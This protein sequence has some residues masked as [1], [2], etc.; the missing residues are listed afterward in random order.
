MI[1]SYEANDK[2][3]AKELATTAYLD[4]FE[5][6]ES[7]IGK[8]LSDKGESLLREKLRD[9][10]DPNATLDEIKQNIDDINV[11]LDDAAMVLSNSI[12]Q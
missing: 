8:E 3:K 12:A 7:P 4:N 10:I 9:Q 2:V 6:I 11:V 1:P 5:F